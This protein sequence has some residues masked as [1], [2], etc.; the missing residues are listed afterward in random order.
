M[1][2]MEMIEKRTANILKQ[3]NSDKTKNW[4]NSI[5]KVVIDSILVNSYGEYEDGSTI[6]CQSVEDAVKELDNIRLSGSPD[7]TM[8]T[9]VKV[10]ETIHNL[11][12]DMY[13]EHVAHE[14]PIETF[15][16]FANR[17]GVPA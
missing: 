15:L 1:T 4:G 11:D 9:V 8:T 2:K 10:Y 16:K 14:W 17:E 12:N 5:T 3:M 13:E 6:T 7:C